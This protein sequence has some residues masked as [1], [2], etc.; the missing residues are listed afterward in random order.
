MTLIERHHEAHDD[1]PLDPPIAPR[2]RVRVRGRVRTLR[3]TFRLGLV[4]GSG[5]VGCASLDPPPE[6]EVPTAAEVRTFFGLLP[7]SAWR[8][9]RA[10]GG[11]ARAYITGPDTASI[12]GKTAYVRRVR[13]Q[14][15]EAIEEAWFFDGDAADGALRILRMTELAKTSAESAT[16]LTRRFEQ[17][18]VPEIG[19]LSYAARDGALKEPTLKAGAR[20]DTESVARLCTEECGEG[21]TETHR[22]SVLNAGEATLPVGFEAYGTATVRMSYQRGG[23]RPASA[24]YDF[25]PGFGL[26]RF[27]DFSGTDYL[28]CAAY[29]CPDEAG[30]IGDAELRCAP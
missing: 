15:S 10:T 25:V 8:Y 24:T 19:R 14:E 27:S 21:E 17:D 9:R 16:L 4:L 3:F 11:T 28:L 23:A 20:F 12:A 1:R 7:G 29:V 26:I 5:A 30:C 13:L 6:T 18:P 22:W 2:G